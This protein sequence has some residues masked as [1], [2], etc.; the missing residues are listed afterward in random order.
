MEKKFCVKV[1]CS[2][3][4]GGL[5]VLAFVSLAG[6]AKSAAPPKPNWTPLKSSSLQA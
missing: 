4:M 3:V 6:T 1:L 5:A 2:S